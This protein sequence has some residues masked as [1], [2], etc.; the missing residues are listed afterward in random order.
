MYK[1]QQF[2]HDLHIK[3][4]IFVLTF[5]NTLCFESHKMVNYKGKHNIV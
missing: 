4:M 3:S 2:E 1:L 5:H